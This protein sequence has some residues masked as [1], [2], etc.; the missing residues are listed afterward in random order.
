M[1]Y[2]RGEAYR[3]AGSISDFERQNGGAADDFDGCDGHLDLWKVNMN[4]STNS[5]N[6]LHANDG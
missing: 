3:W 1:N 5:Q 4:V 6:L 2:Q